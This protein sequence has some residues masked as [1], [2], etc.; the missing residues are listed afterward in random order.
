MPTYEFKC[1]PCGTIV[2]IRRA[3]TDDVEEKCGTCNAVMSKVFFAAP[4]H[5]RG[6]GWGKDGQ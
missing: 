4:A 6:T 5:F 1:E 3:F 2:E